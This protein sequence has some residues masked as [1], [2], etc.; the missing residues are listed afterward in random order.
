MN[1][2]Y[3]VYNIEKLFAVDVVDGLSL[4]IGVVNKLEREYPGYGF[5]YMEDNMSEEKAITIQNN[6]DVFLKSLEKK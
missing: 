6:G 5:A 1:D 3:M 4:A 2:R